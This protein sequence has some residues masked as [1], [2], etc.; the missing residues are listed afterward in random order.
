VYYVQ[1]LPNCG[2][3]LFFDSRGGTFWPDSKAVTNE[4]RLARTYHRVTP[5][6]GRLVLFPNY[7][8]HMVETNLSN[9]IRISIAMELYDFPKHILKLNH[10]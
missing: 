5:K 10:N 7:V 8:E 6:P 4:V 9:D 1:A 2:D 3:I